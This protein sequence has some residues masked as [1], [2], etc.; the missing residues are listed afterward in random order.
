MIINWPHKKFLAASPTSPIAELIQ[1]KK[2]FDN[3]VDNLKLRETWGYLDL[4]KGDTPLL[5]LNRQAETL[6]GT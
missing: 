3:L 5:D 2:Y 1:H 6:C 4:Y